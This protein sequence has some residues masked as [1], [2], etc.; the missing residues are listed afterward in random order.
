MLDYDF[1]LVVWIA[2][3][4]IVLILMLSYKISYKKLLILSLFY[5]YVI[6]VLGVTF[7]PLPLHSY[8]WL[9]V[10][11]NIKM[12]L[13]PFDTIISQ[14]WNTYL[15]FEIKLKQVWGNVLMFLPFGF[16]YSLITQK[17]S[18]LKILLVSFI[19]SLGIEITQLLLWLILWFN[20]RVIDIDDVILN[21]FGWILWYLFYIFLNKIFSLFTQK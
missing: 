10:R 5:V 19:F 18:F 8:E 15:P 2:G 11:E 20:Y 12:N 4:F 6:C 1:V 7:F 14:I 17:S 16:L 21:T 3:Y 13:I 9:I